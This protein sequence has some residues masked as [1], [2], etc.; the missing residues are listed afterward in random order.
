MIT[1][2]H[3]AR[4]F[5]AVLEGI[6]FTTEYTHKFIWDSTSNVTRNEWKLLGIVPTS[7][8]GVCHSSCGVVKRIGNNIFKGSFYY[9]ST[10]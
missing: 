4:C 2:S 5:M 8:V 9:H 10:V 6:K 1:E 3:S 7:R